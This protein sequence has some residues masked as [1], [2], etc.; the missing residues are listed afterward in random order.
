[1]VMKKVSFILLAVLLCAGAASAADFAPTLLKLSADPVVQYDFDGSELEIPVEVSGS[2]AGLIFAVYTKDMAS[3]IPE[4]V[5]GFLGWHHVNKIDTCIYFSN[6]NSV[7]IGANTVSWDGTNNDGA[8][9]PAGEYTYYVWGFDNQGT[10]Q[11]MSDYL[12]SRSVYWEIQEVDTE[13]LPLADPFY[14]DSV[15]YMRWTLGGDPMD[16]TLVESTEVTMTEGWGRRYTPAID[17]DNFDYFYVK[18]LNND[19]GTASIN[20]WKWVPG[21]AAEMQTDFGDNGWAEGISTVAGGSDSGLLVDNNFIY[22]SDRDDYNADTPVDFYILDRDGYIVSEIDL[23][24]WWSSLEDREAGAQANGGPNGMTMRNGMI[25]LNCHCS[26]VKQMVDPAGYLETE[27]DT[28]FFRWTNRNG[29]YILDHNFEETASLK[30][31]CMDYN[32]GPYTYNIDADANLFSLCPAYDVGAV[33]FGLM[34][35]DGSGIG[36][37]AFS[38]ETAGWKKTVTYIDSETPFD[39]MYCDNQQAGGTH[40]QEGGWK[41]NE[42]TSGIYF[43][44]H[45]SIKGVITNA[46]A[47]ENDAPAAF[48]VDQNVPNPFNPSTTISFNLANAGDV[49]IDVFNVAGQKVDTLVDGFMDAGSHSVVWNAS[50]FSA[51]VYFYTVRSG[52]FSKTIKMTL[53]K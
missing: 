4:T 15:S 36:Y 11:K 23:Q 45:D 14:Y 30:W 22:T 16:S 40:Y 20:K 29:D 24:T 34:G 25:F 10:K 41:S 32:V 17:P 27:T 9:V 8:V 47:V 39:G 50:A 12:Y 21:G 13:G 6:L 33:S 53:V 18:V 19:A 48:A 3:D 43:L 52:G 37:F 31:A 49:T 46:V 2:T 28:D 44:G 26:C 7:D 38:G 1:M 42:Y 5:N 51:G 35:P